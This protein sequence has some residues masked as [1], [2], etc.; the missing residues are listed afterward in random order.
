MPFIVGTMLSSDKRLSESI[1]KV[2][3]IGKTNSDLMRKNMGF[4]LDAKGKDLTEAKSFILGKMAEKG[5]VLG[6]DLLRTRED[7]IKRLCLI[8][9]YR[10]LRH[11]RGLPVRGQ[12]THSNGKKRK[13][14]VVRGVKK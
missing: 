5:L 1:R 12:R 3:G 9:S 14:F 11:K 10:G 2:Y 13:P 8:K 6:S 4:G 7:K